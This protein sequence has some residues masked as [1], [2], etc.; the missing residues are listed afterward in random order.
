MTFEEFQAMR[1]RVENL[2]AA[3]DHE[4]LDGLPGFVYGDTQLH[5]EANCPQWAGSEAA[6]YAYLL[7][8]GNQQYLSDDLRE[9]ETHLYDFAVSEGYFA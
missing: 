5:I 8:I 9:V 7:V 1:T 3:V 4:G 6:G 2:G